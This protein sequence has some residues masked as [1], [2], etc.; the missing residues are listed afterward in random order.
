MGT[1]YLST[2]QNPYFF[3]FTW[4]KKFSQYFYFTRVFLNMSICT[5]TWVKDVCTFAISAWMFGQLV[6][7]TSLIGSGLQS[8][9]TEL[10]SGPNSC[11][12]ICI[13]KPSVAKSTNVFV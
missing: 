1:F 13:N 3:T 9:T 2:F 5:S 8:V 11:L 4:V 12:I 10:S 7:Q 6:I